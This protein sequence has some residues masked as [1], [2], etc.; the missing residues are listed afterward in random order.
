MSLN[1]QEAAKIDLVYVLRQSHQT[2][3]YV[4]HCYAVA[5]DTRSIDRIAK[6]ECRRCFYNRKIGGCVVT[7]RP[8][9]FCGTTLY[10][11]TTCIDVICAECAKSRRLCKHCGSDIEGKARRKV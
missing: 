3:H 2:T 1:D 9:A 11:G 4:E 5:N 10:S 7:S 8:C 6:Q